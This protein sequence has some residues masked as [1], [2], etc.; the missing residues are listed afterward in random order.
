MDYLKRKF[1]GKPSH[2]FRHKIYYPKFG[3]FILKVYRD[4]KSARNE[5]FAL[6]AINKKFDIAPKLLN[7]SLGQDGFSGKVNKL[8]YP[9]TIQ[10]KIKGESLCLII[11]KEVFLQD[12]IFT[13]NKF[14]KLFEHSNGNE[15]IKIMKKSSNDFLSILKRQKIIN[16]PKNVL[17]HDFEIDESIYTPLTLIHGDLRNKHIFISQDKKKIKIID[18][19]NAQNGDALVDLAFIL[20]DNIKYHKKILFIIKKVYGKERFVLL[21]FYLYYLCLRDIF[22]CFSHLYR[23]SHGVEG[24]YCN[25]PHKEILKDI[26]SQI[27]II[28]NLELYFYE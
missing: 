9:F 23:L 6:K 19:E 10:E 28:N 3:N 15:F 11:K 2:G 4:L 18:W 1:V 21:K 5:V 8:L 20:K 17:E 13:L 25:I 7:Y 27:K 16:L 22:Q 24:I 14:H 12:I 26:D